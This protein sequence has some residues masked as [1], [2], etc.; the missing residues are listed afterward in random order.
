[1]E[2]KE[3][4]CEELMKKS[5]SE[6]KD[7]RRVWDV[8]NR[9]LLYMTPELVNTFLKVREHPRYKKTIIE[10]ETKLLKQNAGKFAKEL[11]NTPFNLIDMG[12]ED[13]SKAKIFIEALQGKGNVRFC[14]VN[15]SKALAEMASNNLKKAGFKN[16]TEFK[17][18]VADFKSLYEVATMLRSGDYQKNAILLLGWILSSFEIH[19]YLFNL[20]QAMF[21]GDILMI[22]NGI[23]IGE[24]FVNIETYRHSLFKGWF[25]HLIRE[26]GFKEKEVTYDARFANGRVE[27]FYTLKVGKTLT[28]KGKKI[29]L[30]KGDE[31]VVAFLYKYFEKE[32]EEFCRM[33]FR[34][35]ELVKDED[36]EYALI[37]CRK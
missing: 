23:R 5:Y 35:V 30:R 20:S 36:S 7:G 24:R 32:L 26:L 34:S 3:A 15:V 17:S 4:L 13:G 14:S 25:D 6:L 37:M 9:S 16:V 31:I 21:K 22:G 8:A 10:I 19:D 33:Y 11:E 28:Y 2:L 12:C 18:H 29:E 27:G 1:M